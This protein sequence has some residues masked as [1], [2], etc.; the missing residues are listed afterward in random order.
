VSGTLSFEDISSPALEIYSGSLT[1]TPPGTT[2]DLNFAIENGGFTYSVTIPSGNVL[3]S[4]SGDW[5]LGADTG[6]IS[7]T[8]SKGTWTCTVDVGSG[9][10]TGPGTSFSWK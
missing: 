3:V 1:V 9:S 6:T 5:D 2:V 4:A 8:D 7:I 10:C